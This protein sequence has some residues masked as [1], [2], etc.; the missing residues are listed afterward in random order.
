MTMPLE[1]EDEWRWP[2]Y[3]YLLGQYLGD[4][5]ISEQRRKVFRMRIT[6]ANDWPLVMELVGQA[7]E[8]ILP[9]NSAGRLARD[10]CTE[11]GMSSKRW[12][13]LVPQ[14]G[15]GVKHERTL[16]LTAWQ[17]ALVLEGHPGLFVCGLLHS[18]GCRVTNHVTVRGR[19]YA[20]PRY[21]FSNR[22]EDIHQ[23]F[24]RAI[25]RLGLSSTRSGWNQ[26][27]ARHADVA[28]LDA[29]GAWKAKP[30]VLVPGAGIEP[31]RS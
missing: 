23:M 12:P 18:D 22:S 1:L 28:L 8:T 25:G 5:C 31:A 29:I 20:Y 19:R 6:C 11:V 16:R 10:G 30:C 3:A 4:G 15:S 7:L 24:A 14:H 21:F 13:A 2:A 26:S 17:E 27:V 9:R